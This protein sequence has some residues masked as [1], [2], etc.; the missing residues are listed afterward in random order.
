MA[1]HANFSADIARYDGNARLRAAGD[2]E[3]HVRTLLPEAGDALDA[4]GVPRI[5]GAPAA[6]GLYFCGFHIVPT[7]QL[8]E[9][10]LEALRIARDIARGAS[11]GASTTPARLT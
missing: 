5:S 7:G 1:S 8:R 10:G 4:R 6:P 11:A 3:D 2:W 9:I